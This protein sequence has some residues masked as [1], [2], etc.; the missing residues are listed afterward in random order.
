MFVLG[1]GDLKAQHDRR[2]D[3]ALMRAACAATGVALLER[4]TVMRATVLADV[5][6]LG[7]DFSGV[8]LR[9]VLRHFVRCGIPVNTE[10]RD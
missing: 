2:L 5:A 3:L 7:I 6:Q 1:L 10:R 4:G 9:V 8:I